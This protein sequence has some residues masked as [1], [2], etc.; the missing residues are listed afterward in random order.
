MQIAP[1]LLE[2]WLRDYYFTAEIDLGSSGVEDFS[3]S[4]VREH[5]G[6]TQEEMDAVI[7]RDSPSCGS[8]ELRQAIAKRWGNGDGERVMATTGS[9]EALFL[10]MHALL[11]P[12]DKVVVLDPCY[13]SLGYIAESINCRLKYWRLD[14]ER[15]FVPDVQELKSLVEPDTRMIVVNFPHNPT[16]A[17][18]SVE[19]Q[20]EIIKLASSVGAYLM[21][22]SAFAELTYER[23][24][25]PD[26]SQQYERAISIGTLSKGYGLP[27]L[28]VGWV[29]AAPEV[30]A[31]CMHLRDYTSLY[32]SPLVEVIA[33]R[34]VQN[35]EKLIGMRLEQA[36]RNRE[37]VAEWIDRQEGLVEWAKP[38]GGVTAFVRF[39]RIHDVD[40]FCHQLTKLHKVLLVPGSC[41]NRPQHARLGF[42]GPTAA[43]RQGLA[44][45]SNLL[46]AHSA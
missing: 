19:E 27:G 20:A 25:L 28:R 9:S 38:Q 46:K 39:P 35:A 6:L 31:Q 8:D 36:R 23:P 1:A 40:E 26:A 34:A 22:D 37:I 32:L 3:L 21:W 43:V 17:T 10:A 5:T 45:V 11:Q 13:H 33:L 42:G 14:F 2:D 30:L 18:V 24:S 15:R 29:Q 44:H 7:F 41:F 16:G 12:G 4:E